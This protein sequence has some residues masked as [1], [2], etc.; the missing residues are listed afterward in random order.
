[1]LWESP[2]S[3]FLIPD[4]R[5]NDSRMSQDWFAVSSDGA[6]QVLSLAVPPHM[7]SADIDRLHELVLSAIGTRPASRWVIDLAAMSYM[8]SALLG[9]MVNVRQRVRQGGGKLV[10]CG[11]SDKLHQVF[12]TCSLERLFIIRNGRDEAVDAVGK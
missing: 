10:L 12:K 6:V 8:G 5:L 3:P 1:M 2:A 11:M 7:D 4:F 9:L